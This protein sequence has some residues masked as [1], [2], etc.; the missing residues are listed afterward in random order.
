MRSLHS[1]M[2]MVGEGSRFMKEGWTTPKPL[3]ELHGLPLFK[4][5]ISSITILKKVVEY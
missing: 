5:A 2:P 4:R 1:I 3:I